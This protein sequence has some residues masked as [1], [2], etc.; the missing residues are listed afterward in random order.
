MESGELYMRSHV[1]LQLMYPNRHI[2]LVFPP[3][4]PY[5]KVSDY[6]YIR[7]RTLI[8]KMMWW[9]RFKNRLIRTLLIIPIGILTFCIG[10][11]PL[12]F[13]SFYSPISMYLSPFFGIGISVL[14]MIFY[15]MLEMKYPSDWTL[16]VIHKNKKYS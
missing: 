4:E 1:G 5:K 6:L 9:A 12:V 3:I 11:T 16:D 8:S 7:Q 15:D 14:V 13:I 10:V 2:E